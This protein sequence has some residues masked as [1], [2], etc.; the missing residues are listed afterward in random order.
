[1]TN[2]SLEFK[3][4]NWLLD[5]EQAVQYA[6]DKKV[7]DLLKCLDEQMHEIIKDQTQNAIKWA[8]AYSDEKI[9]KMLHDKKSFSFNEFECLY[10]AVCS[11]RNL[12]FDFALRYFNSPLLCDTL[13]SGACARHGMP[14]QDSNAPSILSQIISHPSWIEQS[15]DKTIKLLDSFLNKSYIPQKDLIQNAKEIASINVQ[16]KSISS[17]TPI[18]IDIKKKT[19]RI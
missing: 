7:K 16:K 14:I 4:H 9:I 1:M 11:N 8:Y 18:S 12:N 19:N 17:A 10:A 2:N 5:L 6:D 3:A 13:L 15:S